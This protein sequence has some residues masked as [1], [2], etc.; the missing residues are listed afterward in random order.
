MYNLREKNIDTWKIIMHSL[1]VHWQ[2]MFYKTMPL[3][4]WHVIDVVQIMIDDDNDDSG[5]MVMMVAIVQSIQTI[6]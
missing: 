2:E 3:L 4:Y 5:M 1:E 6:H